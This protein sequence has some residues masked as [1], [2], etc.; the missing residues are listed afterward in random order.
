MS[1]RIT[2]GLEECVGCKACVEACFVDVLRW[3]DAAGKPRIAYAEDCVWCFTCELN[4]PVRCITVLPRMQ[5]P[6]VQPY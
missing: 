3:D 6:Q 1:A 2:I 5:G 4:C